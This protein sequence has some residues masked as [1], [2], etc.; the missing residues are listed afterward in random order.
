MMR[1]LRVHPRRAW[2]GEL[3]RLF[4]FGAGYGAVLAA[5]ALGTVLSI[6]NI[7]TDL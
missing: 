7:L 6:D 2:S 4:T 5:P 3:E 1:L